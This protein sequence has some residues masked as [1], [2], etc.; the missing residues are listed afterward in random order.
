MI[1][2]L[3]IWLLNNVVGR[4]PA[5]KEET[6]PGSSEPLTT[7][8]LISV[9]EEAVTALSANVQD[10]L[11]RQDD[12]IEKRLERRYKGQSSD[13]HEDSPRQPSTSSPNG[14]NNNGKRLRIGQPYRR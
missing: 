11:D 13:S 7:A 2:K 1:R 6:Q 14:N 3:I 5:N 8:D 10:M 12:K 9:L 4:A